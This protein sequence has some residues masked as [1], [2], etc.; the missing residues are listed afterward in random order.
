MVIV[1]SAAVFVCVRLRKLR[2]VI[3]AILVRVIAVF[4]LVVV[5]MAAMEE[6]SQL[7]C[8]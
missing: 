7:Q 4:L 8:C 2:M 6:I 5:V 1:I 3:I